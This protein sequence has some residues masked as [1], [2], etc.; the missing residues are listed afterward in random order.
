M[1]LTVR[2]EWAV[3]HFGQRVRRVYPAARMDQTQRSY[4]TTTS[5]LGVFS[6]RQYAMVQYAEQLTHVIGTNRAKILFAI[7]AKKRCL[8]AIVPNDTSSVA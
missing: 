2:Q 8:P 5:Y 7:A 3:G 6:G 4:G 1:G